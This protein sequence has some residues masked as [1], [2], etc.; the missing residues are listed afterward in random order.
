[1]KMGT[2]KGVKLTE[3]KEVL[4]NAGFKIIRINPYKKDFNIFDGI[5]EIQDFIYESCKKMTKEL[6]K[7][8]LVELTEKLNTVAK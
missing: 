8:S 7:K 1:M 5:S 3:R 6:N 4:E 2:L